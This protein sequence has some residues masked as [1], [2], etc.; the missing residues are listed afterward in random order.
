MKALVKGVD[1]GMELG[2]AAQPYNILVKTLR[3]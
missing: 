3:R 1:E 2:E